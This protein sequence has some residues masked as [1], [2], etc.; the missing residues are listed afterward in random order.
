MKQF[1]CTFVFVFINYWYCI[2]TVWLMNGDISRYVRCVYFMFE[3]VRY[4][5]T[6]MIICTNK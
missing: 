6:K 5:L 3:N 1:E 2:L 4:L